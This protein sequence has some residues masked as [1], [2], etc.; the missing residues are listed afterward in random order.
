MDRHKPSLGSR[1]VAIA[2]V[3]LFLLLTCACTDLDEITQFAKAS[4]DV[5]KAFPGIADQAEA[6]CN[7]ANS[8]KNAQNPLPL[9]PCDVYAKLKPPLV[10]VNDALFGY[11]ASLGKLATADLS[12]VSGGFDSLGT[13]LKQGD[14]TISAANLSKANAAAGLAKAITNI[15]ANGYRQ[16]E[17]SRIVRE[18][19][20]AVQEVTQFLSDYAADKYQQSFHDE[21]RYEDSYCLNMKSP[22][23]PVATDLLD[24]KCAADKVRIETQEKAIADYQKALATIAK[25]HQKLD[26]EAGHWNAQQLA[27]DLGPEIVTLGNA[28]VSVNKAF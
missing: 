25:T 4:Q 20:Q 17:L 1:Q 24:R 6:A 13:D 9:L 12:K 16:R 18:N 5:G 2:A 14:P 10:K 8:F 15:W 11:I 27:K 7:R 26:E 23:E 19:N 21:W 22:T 28:A 3:A